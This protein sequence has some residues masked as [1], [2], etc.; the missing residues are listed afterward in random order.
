MFACP[1]L[2]MAP[3]FFLFSLTQSCRLQ[4]NPPSLTYTRTLRCRADV[5]FHHIPSSDPQKR[6]IQYSD[7]HLI[8]LTDLFLVCRRIE[9]S[10]KGKTHSLVFPPLSAKHLRVTNAERDFDDEL[11]STQLFSQDK[12]QRR[13]DVTVM[14]RET[15]SVTFTS[16]F[17]RESWKTAFEEAQAFAA[18]SM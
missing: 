12:V 2:G 4:I 14:K 1:F 8:L 16:S 6:K 18:A 13:L 15:L 10:A 3:N 5:F 11:D 7:A 9:R 17:E